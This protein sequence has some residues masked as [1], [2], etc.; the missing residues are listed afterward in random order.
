MTIIMTDNE[1]SRFRGELRSAAQ[2]ITRAEKIVNTA[3]ASG[4]YDDTHT[5]LRSVKWEIST[6]LQRTIDEHQ[7][8]IRSYK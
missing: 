1:L 8:V 6:T 5:N 3:N 7:G 4:N 2:A